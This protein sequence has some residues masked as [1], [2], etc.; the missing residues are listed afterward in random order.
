MGADADSLRSA[1]RD[2]A[3]PWHQSGSSA[4]YERLLEIVGGAE[5]VL[6][7]EASHGTHEFYAERAAITRRLIE[8]RGFQAVAVEADWPDAARVNSYVRGA[9]GDGDAEQALRDFRRF[10][11]WM[12]RNRDV[13]H[14]VEW[15]RNHNAGHGGEDGHV[16]FYGLDLY[17]LQASADAI[18]RYLDQIDPAAA[19]RARER[20][21]CFEHFGGEM[22]AY[23]YATAVGTAEACEDQVVEQLLELQERAADLAA[24]DGRVPPDAHFFA[25]QNAR[26]VQNAERYY[27]SMFRGRA[28]SWNLRDE[29]MAETL[30]A[31]RRHL[32]AQGKVVVWAHNSHIGDARTTEMADRGELNLGQLARER[33]RSGARLVGFTTYGGTV[34]AASDWDA[35]AERKRVRPG[36]PGSWEDILH[37]TGLERLLLALDDDPWGDERSPI[38]LL[39]RAIGVI[40]RPET[41]RLSHYFHARLAAQFDALVHID[42]TKA[43]QPLEITPRW[44]TGEPPET[45]PSGV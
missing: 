25:Q 32:G 16:G 36:L 39:E 43:V 24:R 38:S 12:W 41:E 30:D 17:S 44:Q 40:Y 35:P 10:P 22:Q 1:I 29:H 3:V 27:R 26:L 4:G 19:R 15:L 23:G 8:E 11:T 20:Y 6:L 33:Y 34:T 14:F 31:L 9:G 18:V 45:Y 5:V 37:S 42:G 13:V 28:S 21:A 2:V 7:G